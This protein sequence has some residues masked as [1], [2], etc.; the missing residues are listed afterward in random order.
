MRVVPDVAAIERRFDYAV[1][2][3]LDPLIRVGS[4]VRITLHGRR[5]GAWVTDDGVVP[6][7]G[8]VPVPLAASSGDGPPPEVVDLADWAAWRWAGP[9]AAF[10]GTASPPRVVRSGEAGPARATA[11]PAVAPRSPGGGSVGLVAAALEAPVPPA[12]VRLAPA[13]DAALLVLEVVHRLGPAGLL[14]L[15]PE[16]A[17]A[18]QL[19]TRLRAEGLPVAALPDEWERAAVG[20][21]VA[22]GTRSAAWAPVATPAGAVVLDAHDEAY[23]ET[24]APTWSAVD[25]VVERCRRGGVPCLLVSPCPPLLRTEGARL[26]TMDRGTERHGWPVVEP[27]D[28]TGE[29]P[30]TG[31]FSERLVRAARDVLVRPEGRVVCILN[32]TGR[33]RLLACAACGSLARC[34]ACGAAVDQREAGDGLACRRCGTQRP[35]VCAAC[36]ST[37][38][39][40]LR[41]GVTRAAEEL[42]AL[43][44]TEALEVSG[45]RGEDHGDEARLVVGTEAALHRVARADLVAFLDF[46]QHLLAPRFAAGEEALVLLARAARLTGG[47][48]GGRVLLQTRVPAHEAIAAAVHADPS[49][50]TDAERTVRQA[51]GLPPFGALAT[52]R[53]PGGDELADR[54]RDVA[55]LEVS[56]AGP[57]RRLVRATDHTVLCD[58]L[59]AAGRPAERVRIEV[60]PVDV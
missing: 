7:E 43:L 54:L 28:R 22:V 5:V 42:A 11:G 25:V 1:P 3:S 17:G 51:L 14:V 40:A 45:G 38:L 46:D 36:D 15:A 30:R 32:R 52:V 59:A 6:D 31:L 23:R 37:R 35:A 48:G 16:H 50:L 24:R 20:R 53:G 60:D 18:R 39:R 10:L 58:R 12:V 26:V 49:I 13:Y 44:G 56:S 34:T 41:I 4:R 57:E 2:A 33:M 47:R 9:V 27:V 55:L 8:V 19:V 21:S 29:D